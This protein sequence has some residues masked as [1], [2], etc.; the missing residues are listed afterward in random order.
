MAWYNNFIKKKQADETANT[1]NYI[2]KTSSNRL[3]QDLINLRESLKEAEQYDANYRFRN[4]MQLI[5]QDILNDGHLIACIN[6][7]KS[8][9]LKKEYQVQDLK[10]NQ[11]EEWTMFLNSKWFKDFI[12]IALDAQFFGYSGVN[13]TGIKENKLTGLK[14]IRRD[15][16]KPD[17]NEILRMPYSYEGISFEDEKIKDWSLLIKTTDNL[18]Y[19]DCGYGLFFPCSAYAIAIRN[20]LGFNIDFVEKFIIPFVVAKTM[21]HEG[22]ERDLLEKGISNM[23]SS[24]SVVLDP[25]DEIEFIESKNAGSGYNSFD[26]LENRCEKKISKIILGHSDAID[27]TSGKLGSNQNEAVQEALENIE[28][29]DNSFIENIVN[30]HFFDKIRNLGFNIP[31]GF[32]FVFLNTHE[33][34][35]KLENESKVNQ[36]FANVVKT[37]KE[38]GHEVDSKFVQET[39]GYPT[40]KI[41]TPTNVNPNSI[42]NLYGL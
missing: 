26:N 11:S 21:K 6:A 8:L 36:L 13:W 27:S 34:T 38:S 3:R 20:N 4:K 41:L 39:T 17:T 1:S 29:I 24:N 25:N 33:K 30:D 35:E 2:Q 19:S 10:G 5:F 37:L 16:I 31:K 32:K 7:R 42:N 28:V 22:D 14:T 18:G 9:T 12:S 23:A 15:S 40:S